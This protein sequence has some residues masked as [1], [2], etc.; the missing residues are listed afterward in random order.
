MRHTEGDLK[1][2]EIVF[3]VQM[4]YSQRRTHNLMVSSYWMSLQS[5]KM[6]PVVG[7]LVR[8]PRN[9]RKVTKGRSTTANPQ[10]LLELAAKK[11]IDKL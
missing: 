2:V 3:A 10:M 8:T 7:S 11:D 1:G 5:V 9:P 4:S 6:P